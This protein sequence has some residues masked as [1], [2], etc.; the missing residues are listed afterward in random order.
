MRRGLVLMVALGGCAHY[1]HLALS[2][3]L[4]LEA[5]TRL[6]DLGDRR[7]EPDDWVVRVVGRGAVCSGALV[8]PDVVVTAQHCTTYDADG[9]P[10]ALNDLRVEL[11]GDYLPWGRVG[12][13]GHVPCP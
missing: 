12:V 10:Y 5:D 9:S 3:Q 6:F 7:A 13:V 4:R 1:P 2:T 11:G 8:A